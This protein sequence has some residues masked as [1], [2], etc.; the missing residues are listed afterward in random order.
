MNNSLSGKHV[1][2]IDSLPGMRA[3]MQKTLQQFGFDSPHAVASIKDALW[4]LQSVNYSLILCDYDL[5]EGTDGQQ[6][7]E[8]LRTRDLISRNTI[9]VMVTAERSYEKVVV[10]AECAPDDYLLKPFTTE[11]FNVRID[12][13]LERQAHFA[14]VDRATD[15]KDWELVVAECER[16][17]DTGETYNIEA[18]KIKGAALLKM[19]RA[20]EAAACFESVLETHE[21][22][23][24][25]LGLAR[26]L[27]M[28]GDKQR[29][30]AMAREII[31]D[32][33]LFLSAYDFLSEAL[34]GIGDKKGALEVLQSARRVSPGT[35][36]R[37]R[38]VA[39]LAIETGRH[40]IAEHV[41]G[42]ALARH[43]YS[44][45]I[46]SQ[47]YATLARV[48]TEEGWPDK[49]LDVI[50]RGRASFDDE[51]SQVVLAT[52][53]SMAHRRAGHHAMAE[54]ALAQALA[55]DQGNL[56][57]EAATAVAQACLALG[58]VE[59]GTE[60]LKRVVQNYPDDLAVQAMAR[61]ALAA[62]GTDAQEAAEIVAASVQE[63][64]H[65]N[66]EGVRKAEAG[67][68]EEAV[69]LLCDAADRLPNNL[70]I[71]S[72]ASLALAL[73]MLRH[74][75]T[76]IKMHECLRYRQM[77]V[78]KSL[79]YPKLVQIDSTLDQIRRP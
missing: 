2:I 7:L 46:E 15:A 41:L 48:L 45:V 28:L 69:N 57:P 30:I 40:D 60:L 42:E 34:S 59:R 16:L 58:Q 77:V 24:A 67:E 73:D 68:L 75:Y 47:D 13:L 79:H 35:L 21:L 8:Y 32:H 55:A 26:A 53:E 27:A 62:S 38:Q 12:R 29:A 49:A 17:L 20:Q 66:N 54:A 3:Q 64:I 9:F 71:V 74:G 10:A 51:V 56:P 36:S 63:I 14:A 18:S 19:Q 76:S 6:F 22:P 5:G 31:D 1:L 33:E 23:W 50:S 65:L 11:Q 44:P 43:R 78:A 70:Q 52:G 4:H 72:N 37:I 39:S 61:A 25:K